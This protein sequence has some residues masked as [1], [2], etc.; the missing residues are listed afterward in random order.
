MQALRQRGGGGATVAAIGQR[1]RPATK[2]TARRGRRRRRRLDQRVAGRHPHRRHRLPPHDPR[3]R[4]HRRRVGEVEAPL[5]ARPQDQPPPEPHLRRRRLSIAGKRRRAGG[6]PARRRGRRQAGARAPAH[7]VPPRAHAAVLDQSVEFAA[8]S[9]TQE[10]HL[11]LAAGGEHP[12]DFPHWR[13]AGGGRLRR[14][15]LSDVGLDVITAQ[16]QLGALEG[17]PQ[18]TQLHLTRVA[19]D[20]AGVAS[21]LAACAALTVL[22]LNECHRLVHVAA[23]HD[24]LRV[25]NVGHK[26]DI[27]Y[28][29]TPTVVRLIIMLA[30]ECPLGCVAIGGGAMPKL[31]R[32]FLQFPSPLEARHELQRQGW[33]FGSL[34]QLVLLFNTPWREHVATVASLLVAAPF[35]KELR[36]EAYGDLPVPPPSKQMIQWPKHSSPRMLESIV[37]GGFSGEPELMEL[38]FFPLHKSPAIKTLT[39]DTHRRHFRSNDRGWTREETEDPVRCY[40]ARGVLWKHLAPRIPSTVKLTVI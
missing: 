40:Y 22:E 12:Y 20:D 24:G 2:E 9:R 13:F 30:K 35:V 33:R 26:V 7:A 32:L 21:I 4:G 38:A 17:L 14:L 11:S 27:K 6:G 15:V 23:S 16:Q 25:L 28:L 8:S 10:L 19:V 1:R 36:V 5:E 31:K 39:V 37:V 18:L 3:R 29:H 34:S